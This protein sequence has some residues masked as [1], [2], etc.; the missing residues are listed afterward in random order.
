MIECTALL[1]LQELDLA[2]DESDREVTRLQEKLGRLKSDVEKEEAAVLQ[3]EALLKKINLRRRHTESGLNE[4]ID[5]IA[6]TDL[7]LKTPGLTP[8][9]YMALQ[10]EV[11]A[12]RPGVSVIET[13][14]LED[15]E[16]VEV[17]EKD[18]EKGRKIVAGRKRQVEEAEQRTILAIRECKQK[19]ELLRTQRNQTSLSVNADL[20][21]H[22]EELRVKTKGKVIW[23]T[24]KAGCPS[25]GMRLPGGVIST[26]MGSPT[27]AEP[28]PNCGIFMR[29]TGIPDGIV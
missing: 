24:D 22:Y 26:L 15:M 6:I 1:A 13:K 28:C 7:R 11:E 21:E 19:R 27:L 2:L 3:K 8:N 25:C 23:D 12:I 18:V 10:K 14:V 17:L 5:R 20:M 29:W 4:L 16:K 9:T